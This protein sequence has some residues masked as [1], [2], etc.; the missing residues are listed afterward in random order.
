MILSLFYYIFIY[1]FSLDSVTAKFLRHR[2]GNALDRR[3]VRVPLLRTQKVSKHSTTVAYLWHRG[4][5]SPC[6]LV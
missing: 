6:Q 5:F 4:C 3:Q 2:Q 1:K